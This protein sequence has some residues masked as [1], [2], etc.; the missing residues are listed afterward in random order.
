MK[1][2]LFLLMACAS[3]FAS[4]TATKPTHITINAACP[5][6]VGTLTLKASTPRST[7]IS[8]LAVFFDATTTTDNATLSGANT[9]FQDV[10]YSWNFGD[11]GASG[12]GSWAY[13]SQA[14]GSAYNQ[15]NSATGAIAAHVYIVP[16]GS[17]DQPYTATLTATDGTNTA[18]CTV[19][20]TAYDPNGSNGF[21]GTA[22]VCVSASGTPVAGSGGCPS[23]AAVK[24]TGSVATALSGTVSGKRFLFKCGD[25]FTDGQSIT[26]TKMSIGAYGSPD[27]SGTQTNRPLFTG[28]LTNGILGTIQLG[29]TSG[30]I[31]IYD[32]NFDA[33]SN[34]FSNAA[35]Q[36][37]N[38]SH[39]QVPY[40]LTMY[41][42]FSNGNKGCFAWYHGAQFAL[43][44]SVCNKPGNTNYMSIFPNSGGNEPGGW[45]GNVFNN[46][47]YGAII[48]NNVEGQGHIHNSAGVEVIRISAGRMIVVENNRLCDADDQGAVLKIHNLN[49]TSTD[50]PWTGIWTEYLEISDNLFCGSSGANLVETA[51]TANIYDERLRTIIT[52]RNFFQGPMQTGFGGDMFLVA[53]TNETIRDNI[54]LMSAT[55]TTTYPEVGINIGKLNLGAVADNFEIY[56]NTFY[57][58]SSTQQAQ[59]AV[60]TIGEMTVAPLNGFMQNNIYYT[61]NPSGEALTIGISLTSNT[62][63]NNSSNIA[64]NPA[65][66]NGSGNFSLITDFKPTANYSGGTTV[67]N[68]Y[69][70]LGTLWSP[71]WD[72]GAEHH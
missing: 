37:A 63:T 7:G 14:S 70:I 15:K 11:S 16:N 34:T 47:D 67:P 12:T 55:N 35:V 56:N 4:N 39:T 8:P 54:F 68:L 50:S 20:V 41:N 9:T 49:D 66:T 64:N 25:T 32:I 22:T 26:P 42:L 65:F 43:V 17:G 19:A 30:D 38:N 44:N 45:S 58:P 27:C 21:P 62:V 31:R 48:G 60:G 69:D 18:S 71:T 33:G 61:L 24:N 53:A 10:Y 59:Y 40:Q 52:E 46:L 28:R 2:F 6:T 1:L 5:V 13:G 36:T 23:G 57:A 51:S 72:L 3:A 29:L